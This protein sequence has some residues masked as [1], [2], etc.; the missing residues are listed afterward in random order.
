MVLDIVKGRSLN[1]GGAVAPTSTPTQEVGDNAA[2]QPGPE[3]PPP[4]AASGSLEQQ[5]S[6]ISGAEAQDADSAQLEAEEAPPALPEPEE[7]W[8]RGAAPYHSSMAEEHYVDQ[9]KIVAEQESQRQAKVR[10]L[11]ELLKKAKADGA[12][13]RVIEEF[14]RAISELGVGVPSAPG[15]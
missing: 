13:T 14:E 2:Y 12:P 8:P 10:R 6:E 15:S 11:Q 3:S 1:Q 5:S 7:G 4:G 9:A